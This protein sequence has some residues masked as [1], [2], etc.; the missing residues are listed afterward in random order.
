MYEVVPQCDLIC[1]SLVTL[2]ADYL[3]TCLLATFMSP[4]RKCIEV[5][6]LKLGYLYFC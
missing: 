6:Y 4:L 2:E 5:I 3:P 1:T